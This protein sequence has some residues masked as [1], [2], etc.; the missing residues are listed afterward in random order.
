MRKEL[1][2]KTASLLMTAAL[3]GML[4]AG[5]GGKKDTAQ[6]QAVTAIPAAE[7]SSEAPVEASEEAP[8]APFFEKGVYANYAEGLEEPE[9]ARLLRELRA[10]GVKLAGEALKNVFHAS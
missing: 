8:K 7:A 3:A 2:V 6:N 1:L 4:L 5:C 9:T 10:A